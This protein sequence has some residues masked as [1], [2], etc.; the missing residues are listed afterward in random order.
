MLSDPESGITFLTPSEVVGAGSSAKDLQDRFP[1]DDLRD[2]IVHDNG[3]QDRKL[4]KAIDKYDLTRWTELCKEEAKKVLEEEAD[5]K[6]AEDEA[7]RKVQEGFA[8]NGGVRAVNGDHGMNGH[9]N[10]E[11][12]HDDEDE[13]VSEDIR[14]GGYEETAEGPIEIEDDDEEEYGE[15]DDGDVEM[16]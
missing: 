10:G 7:I 8:T 9:V 1:S 3:V 6:A 12:H 14:N 11:K 16:A 15:D 4:Q 5:A 2:P 13:D